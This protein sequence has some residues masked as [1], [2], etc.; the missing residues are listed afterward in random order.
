MGRFGD[1]EEGKEV[2][3]VEV[4][5]RDFIKEGEN[6]ELRKREGMEWKRKERKEGKGRKE[7]KDEREWEWEGKKRSEG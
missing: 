6:R 3:K 1:G 5:L 7:G 4:R 2:V